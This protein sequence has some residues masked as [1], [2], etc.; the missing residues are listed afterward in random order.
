MSCLHWHRCCWTWPHRKGGTEPAVGCHFALKD[1]LARNRFPDRIR[2]WRAAS[3]AGSCRPT[4][5]RP[6]SWLARG[7]RPDGADSCSTGQRSDCN[8]RPSQRRTGRD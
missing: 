3:S 4:G 8:R 1:P 5:A 7:R 6:S 2:G